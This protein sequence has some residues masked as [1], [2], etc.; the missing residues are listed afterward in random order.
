MNNNWEKNYPYASDLSEADLDENSSLKKMLR[1]VGENKRVLDVGC[2]TGY[3]AE[4]LSKK[5]CKVTGVEIN[6]QAAKE[7]EK[8][9]EKVIVADLDFVAL[10]NILP[11]ELF[12]VAV[13]GDVLEHLRD[14]WTILKQARQ[15]LKPDG[16]VV[17]S[18]PNIAHGAIRLA[19]LEGSFQYM[20]LGILDNTH[21]RFFTR[22]T[23]EDL[24]ERSGY[25]I[26]EMECTKLPIFSDSNLVPCIEKI[27]YD[28]QIIQKIESD[29]DSDT[30][31]FIVRAY[32][33]SLE[34]QYATL[35]EKYLR[36]VDEMKYSQIQI[37]QFRLELE[38][39]Q[40]Q[41]QQIHTQRQEKETELEQVQSQALEKQAELERFKLEIQE[42]Q[43]VWQ[44]AQAQLQQTQVELERLHLQL[45]Q[46]RVDLERSQFQW[47]ETQ[48]EL[49]GSQ[50]QLQQT[51]FQLQQWQL[52]LQQTQ[53]ELERAQITIDAMKSSKFWKIRTVWLSL[54]KAIGMSENA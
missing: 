17:A 44:Q 54:K 16:Y 52:Q 53:T 9:C 45:Q 36:L 10:D 30:L 50:L 35:N 39:S 32:P 15:I 42:K 27:N 24:F 14:P 37:E 51:Q 13:F 25:F 22:E 3:F 40:I 18:I 21:L 47:E 29:Q 38:Q 1:L 6:S 46:N 19:L 26:S 4:L 48:A 41:L 8:Y 23:V 20:E 34:N 12:D 49:E 11:G 43:I 28:S 7:A 5:G 2:A 33:L 31:Q